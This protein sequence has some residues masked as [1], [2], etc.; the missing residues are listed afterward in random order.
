VFSE[1]FVYL[2]LKTNEILSIPL[3]E[4]KEDISPQKDYVIYKPAENSIILETFSVFFN[5]KEDKI[6][7]A[8]IETN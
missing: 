7:L 1:D 2:A 8:V 3:N 4:L 5:E 6:T